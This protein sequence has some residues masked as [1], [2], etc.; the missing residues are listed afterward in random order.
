[1]KKAIK[2]SKEALRL[3]QQT[4]DSSEGAGI[5]PEVPDE[6][7]GKFATKADAEIDWG[8]EDDS[9]QS[10]D[11]YVDEGEITWLSTDEEEKSNEDDDE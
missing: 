9:H 1:M 4:R 3:P 8:S 5:T 7:K 6:G 10:Y 11:E 2:A